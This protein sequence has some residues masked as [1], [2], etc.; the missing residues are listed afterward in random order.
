MLLGRRAFE[1]PSQALGH[2]EGKEQQGEVRSCWAAGGR[3]Q[4]SRRK[5][6][7]GGTGTD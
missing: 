5:K 3:R 7:E 4:L 6:R 2:R 1:S